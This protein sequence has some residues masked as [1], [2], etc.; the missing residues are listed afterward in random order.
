[1]PTIDRPM[2]RK[3]PCSCVPDKIDVGGG[4]CFGLFCSVRYVLEEHRSALV[5]HSRERIL[6]HAKAD[7]GSD[8]QWRAY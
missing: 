3:Q 4:H 5:C 2:G 7:G 6:F 1:M 8:G